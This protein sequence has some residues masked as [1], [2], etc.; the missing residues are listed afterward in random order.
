[1]TYFIA[2]EEQSEECTQEKLDN[3]FTDFAET[4][5]PPENTDEITALITTICG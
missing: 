5:G 4:G 3:C 2:G 1:M